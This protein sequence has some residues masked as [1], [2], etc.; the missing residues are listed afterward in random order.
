[1]TT[2]G[3]LI[4]AL[5]LALIA[6]WALSAHVVA[7]TIHRWMWWREIAVRLGLFALV[8]TALQVA[9][10]GGA[11]S[12]A[13]VHA[14]GTGTLAGVIGTVLC[15]VGIGL[16]V[17]ARAALGQSWARPKAPGAAPEL[18]TT[19]PYAYVRHPIYGGMLLGMLGSSIGQSVLWLLPLMVYGPQFIHSARREER[20][21]LEQYPERYR[22]YM[23]Q[24]KMLLPFVL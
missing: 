22:A 1:M 11:L 24:T 2:Y 17:L 23:K 6:Y 18:I 3:W 9:A 10:T 4:L 15:A 16:A 5:W 13:R 20:L 14:L 8:A 21:L 12:N 7:R 19:G